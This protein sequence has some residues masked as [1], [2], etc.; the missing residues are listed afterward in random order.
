MQGSIWNFACFG[1][2][3]AEFRINGWCIR[4][5]PCI[6]SRTCRVRAASW[7]TAVSTCGKTEGR[8]GVDEATSANML[9]WM[10]CVRNGKT[11]N[12]D[13]EAGY[14]HSIALCMTIAAIQ[15]GERVTFDDAAQE[16]MA[17]GKVWTG[18]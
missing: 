11:P 18:A 6:G 1:R 10:Q 5:I 16:V 4:S 9:N 17:G 2:T 14:S 12:A 3:R 7:Q 8:A 13:V 15:T